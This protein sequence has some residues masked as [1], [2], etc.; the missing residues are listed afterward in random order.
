[1]SV[2]TL[3]RL[4][5]RP[6]AREGRAD[7]AALAIIAFAASTAVFLTVLGGV[8]GFIWRASPDHTPACLIDGRNCAPGT[9]AAWNLR[10]DNPNDPATYASNYVMFAAFACLMLIV[11]FVSLAGA[12]ARLAAT[13][14][15]ARLAAL[16]LAGAT[17]AQVSALTAL[18]AAGQAFVGA[19]AGSIGYLGAMPAVMLLRFQNQ[20]FTFDQLWV[21]APTLAG[22][23]AGVIAIALISAFATL[24]RVAITPLGVSARVR[25]P[26]PAARRALAFAGILG[27]SL[28]AFQNIGLF[29]AAGAAAVYAV[30]FAFM[31]LSFAA[32]N[33]VGVW[34]VAIRAKG[35]ARRPKNAATMLAMRRILDDPKRAWRNVSGI[36]LAVFVAGITSVCALFAAGSANATDPA[37]LFLRDIGTGGVLTLA[38]AAILAAVGSGVMQ[39]GNAL[40]QAGHHRTL[41]LEGADAATLRRARLIETITPLNTV[42]C[43]SAGCSMLLMLPLLGAAMTDPRTLGGFAAGLALCYALTAI[44]TIASN[45]VASGIGLTDGRADD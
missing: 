26:L 8:H 34:A 16:R 12:A 17:T 14:R 38:F 7:T 18:D 28:I 13:R 25:R 42:V 20:P 23:I 30:V 44:G 11:P 37:T 36:A 21:G 31:F 41:L 2:L 10:L 27:V 5:H 22:T 29:A 15:D 32:V 33:A 9:L 19:L 24:R 3:W 45:R 35:K 40:D 39:A 6:D 43:V 1:M 4:L